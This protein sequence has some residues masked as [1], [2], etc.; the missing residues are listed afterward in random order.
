[1]ADEDTKQYVD[2]GPSNKELGLDY[3][4]LRNELKNKGAN[5]QKRLF[6]I[7]GKLLITFKSYNLFHRPFCDVC[8][9][10]YGYMQDDGVIRCKDCRLAL[11]RIQRGRA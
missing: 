1:M 4:R 11:R 7:R 2:C 10:G 6:P 5:P 8:N 3:G 9:S